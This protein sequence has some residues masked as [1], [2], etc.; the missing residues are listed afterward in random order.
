MAGGGAFGL[1]FSLLI[2][3]G[4]LLSLQISGL[5][6]IFVFIAASVVWASTGARD[7]VRFP[8]HE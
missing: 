6:F 5:V 2:I 8:R 7:N 1:V 3:S 4:L